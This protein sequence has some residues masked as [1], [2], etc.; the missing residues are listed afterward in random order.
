MSWVDAYAQFIEQ[1]CERKNMK[2]Y[3]VVMHFSGS[4]VCYVSAPNE[5]E[6]IDVAY[7]ELANMHQLDNL[8]VMDVESCEDSEDDEDDGF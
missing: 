7:D 2:N 3:E 8:E 6:A 5:D 1:L 4:Q